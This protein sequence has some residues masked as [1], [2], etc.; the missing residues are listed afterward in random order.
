MASADISYSELKA[1]IEKGGL[2]L[3]DVRSKEEVDRGCIPGSIHIPLD[4][5][6]TDMA[7]DASAFQQKFGVPK[8]PLDTPDL[9]FHCQMGRRGAAATEK[10]RGL[11]FQKARNYTGGYKEWS[12]KAGK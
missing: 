9:I 1:L 10:A 5:V 3:V 11:G 4:K 12:E 8:P 7:L 6:E 2:L